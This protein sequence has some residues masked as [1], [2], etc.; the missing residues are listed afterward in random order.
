MLSPRI[1]LM[2][3]RIKL[4]FLVHIRCLF[5]EPCISSL[6]VFCI[7]LIVNMVAAMLFLVYVYFNLIVYVF[8]QTSDYIFRYDYY[9]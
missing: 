2:I 1:N 7:H 5:H 3:V 4:E 6:L 9:T 8:N